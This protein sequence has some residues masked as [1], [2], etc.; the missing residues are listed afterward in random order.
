MMPWNQRFNLGWSDGEFQADQA[1][2]RP[3]ISGDLKRGYL[4]DEIGHRVWS[5]LKDWSF[6]AE[7]LQLHDDFVNE[8]LIGDGEAK[9]LSAVVDSQFVQ[10]VCETVWKQDEDAERI[11]SAIKA[12][13][14]LG[15]K[16]LLRYFWRN[17]SAMKYRMRISDEI[18]E[19]REN[20]ARLE[21]YHMMVEYTIV[22]MAYK[23][24]GAQGVKRVINYLVSDALDVAH[25]NIGR[26]TDPEKLM[27]EKGSYAIFVLQCFS[28]ELLHPEWVED[29]CIWEQIMAAKAAQVQAD[30]EE[31]ILPDEDDLELADDDGLTDEDWEALTAGCVI[32]E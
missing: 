24:Y 6:D 7:G 19:T 31:A 25:N 28:G 1:S 9:R 2:D 27:E 30:R 5:A 29:T 8:L 14:P 18:E 26:V 22:S 20:A 3:T 4:P 10:M 32:D 17:E 16:E 11:L 15:V 21:A 12:G 23:A 13:E